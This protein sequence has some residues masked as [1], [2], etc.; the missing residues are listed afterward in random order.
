MLI[1][2]IFFDT[3]VLEIATSRKRMNDCHW[4]S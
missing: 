4:Q 2:A 1:D 3:A